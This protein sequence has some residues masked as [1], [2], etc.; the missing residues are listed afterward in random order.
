M[1]LSP[2]CFPL[3]HRYAP[4]PPAPG[5]NIRE[6]SAR[7]RVFPH[8]ERHVQAVWYDPRWRPANL[9]THR[10]EAI[11]VE[12]PGTWNLEAGPDFLG[13]TLLIGPERRRI[14]GD[15][16]V[17]IFPSGWKQHGHHTDRRYRRVCLHLTYFEGVVPDNELPPGTVQVALRPA[18]KQQP[19]FAFEQIDIAA[20]PY[21]GRADEPPCRKLIAGW[22]IDERAALLEA[23]GHE[24]M[25]VKAERMA[26]AIADAGLDQTLYAAFMTALGYQHNKL[27]F[28]QLAALLPVDRLQQIAAGDTVRAYAVLTGMSGLLPEDLAG[29]WDD[30][31]RSFMRSLWDVWWKERPHLP[32]PLERSDWRRHGIRPLNH[33][34]RRLFAAA[35][36]FAAGAD[37]LARLDTW[38]QGPPEKL[39]TRLASVERTGPDGYW[40]FRSSAGGKKSAARIALVGR[41]RW[42]IIA[43]N[44][45]IPLAAACGFEPTLVLRALDA[46]PPE[47]SNQIIRQTAFYLFGPDHPSLLLE[48]PSRRQ[49]IQQIFHDHC[50]NDRSRCARCRFP[51]ICAQIKTETAS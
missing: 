41:E 11:E 46:L 51:G 39:L 32:A 44:T 13:A 20:Y 28:Q 34:L 4:R 5:G 40:D 17:H 31:T 7:G 10:G 45:V 49:G 15:V 26:A 36:I 25:R 1:R 21:A 14:S 50:I 2:T 35:K 38:M 43:L 33:P 3:A 9:R 8:T 37:A 12:S 47:K 22:T 16:E 30:E 48:T 29:R 27:P 24:R 6:P 19:T 23:A 18:L 42:E